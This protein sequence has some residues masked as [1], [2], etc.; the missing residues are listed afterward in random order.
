MKLHDL[1]SQLGVVMQDTFLF[2]GTVGENI[3]YGKPDAT[4]DDVNTYGYC[5]TTQAVWE[6]MAAQGLV[7]WAKSSSHSKY[8]LVDG[9]LVGGG[10]DKHK[11]VFTGPLNFGNPVTYSDCAMAENVVVIRDD[12]AI[13]QRYLDNFNWLCQEAWLTSNLTLCGD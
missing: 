1:R 3:A 12:A 10:A 13:Y 4:L 2:N 7:R 5:E 8:I 9:P 6:K 11:V